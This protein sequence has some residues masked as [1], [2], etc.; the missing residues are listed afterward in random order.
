MKTD[1]GQVVT[2][3]LKIGRDLSVKILDLDILALWQH[4]VWKVL[5]ESDRLKNFLSRTALGP[6]VACW[7]IPC[8]EVWCLIQITPN[9]LRHSY[10]VMKQKEGNSSSA[11][12][13]QGVGAL[14]P[15]GFIGASAFAEPAIPSSG[16]EGD[17]DWN[18]LDCAL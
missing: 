10:F 2:V 12:T 6:S 4:S 14:D 15:L 8:E 7:G 17:F 1:Q 9:F 11:E 13:S 16:A 18:P 5:F 3:Y